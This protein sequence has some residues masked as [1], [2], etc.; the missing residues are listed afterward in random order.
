MRHSR[1]VGG[2]PARW[3]GGALA[4]HAADKARADFRLGYAVW[5]G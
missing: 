4:P 1:G 5:E 3:R 2:R